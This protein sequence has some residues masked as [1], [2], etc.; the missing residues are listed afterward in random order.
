MRRL[1]RW[2]VAFA[3]LWTAWWAIASYGAQRGLAGAIEAHKSDGWQAEVSQEGFPFRIRS[4]LTGLTLNNPANQTALKA[5]A[6]TLSAPTYWPGYLTL[7]LGRTPITLQ[8]PA[9]DL[10]L[11]AKGTQAGIRLRP[12]VALELQSLRVASNNWRLHSAGQ[13][14]ALADDLDLRLTHDPELANRYDLTLNA[15]KLAPGVLVR[16]LLG[17]APDWPPYFSTF[18]ADA[19]ITF[20]RPIDRHLR[21]DAP[22]QPRA[23]QLHTLDITWG[24]IQLTAFGGLKIDATGVPEGSV[25]MQLSNWRALLDIAQSAGAL[26]ADQRGQTELFLGLLANRADSPDDIDLTLT[27]AAGTM[28]LSGIPLGPAPKLRFE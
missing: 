6:V 10:V 4:R 22:P 18:K 2:L 12:G 26:P 7:D 17:L 14:L 23:L 9:S 11:E 13:D 28:A 25:D 27:F 24:A 16:Q 19:A 21:Q 15:R 1:I 20:D 3:L 5:S 8:T